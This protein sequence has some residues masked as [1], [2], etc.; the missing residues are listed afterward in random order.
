MSV[1]FA[2]WHPDRYSVI[3][4]SSG[5]TLGYVHKLKR[6]KWEAS[7]WAGVN[8]GVKPTRREAAALLAALMPELTQAP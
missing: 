2:A 1:R 6:G 3:Q 4:R 7:T 8:L 5:T